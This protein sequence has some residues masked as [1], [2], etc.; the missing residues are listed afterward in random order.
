MNKRLTTLLAVLAILG[1]M[2]GAKL[3]NRDYR[4][5]IYGGFNAQVI[6][7]LELQ[8]ESMHWEGRNLIL[9]GSDREH[10][11]SSLSIATEGQEKAVRV[12]YQNMGNRT[13]LNGR[14]GHPYRRLV[15]A[16]SPDDGS[17]V[18]V[19]VDESDYFWVKKPQDPNAIV[20]GPHA[21]QVPYPN[22]CQA[23]ESL[24]LMD[25]NEQLRKLANLMSAVDGQALTPN[26]CNMFGMFSGA[27]PFSGLPSTSGMDVTG[28][29][30]PELTGHQ[31]TAECINLPDD[32]PILKT[33]PK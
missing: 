4:Y 26:S 12:H 21:G 11:M 18:G 22:V 3:Q 17:F 20:V 14:D 29:P 15:P 10:L 27:D 19:T 1:A 5:V 24:L 33:S 32:I 16:Y 31:C 13:T 7:T 23:R 6:S 28:Q 30:Q 25:A 9:T 2:V 8:G